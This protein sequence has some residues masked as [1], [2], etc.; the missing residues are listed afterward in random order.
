MVLEGACC[1]DRLDY[2]QM[3]EC[4]EVSP[5]WHTEE[6]EEDSEV[7]SEGENAPETSTSRLHPLLAHEVVACSQQLTV[8]AIRCCY[9]KRPASGRPVEAGEERATR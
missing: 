9:S 6:S 3:L 5:A 7:A 2:A 4:I 8:P 1:T